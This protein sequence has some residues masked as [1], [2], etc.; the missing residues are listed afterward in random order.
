MRHRICFSYGD[1]EYLPIITILGANLKQKN[2]FFCE[3]TTAI[4][5]GSYTILHC[6]VIKE[7]AVLILSTTDITDG[8]SVP[9]TM[10]ESIQMFITY[11]GAGFLRGFLYIKGIEY[12]IL[13][14]KTYMSMQI[15][16]CAYDNITII[17]LPNEFAGGNYF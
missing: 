15:E 11:D 4:K 17:R 14:Y 10:S 9:E 12:P 1:D 13:Q 6:E 7:N 8:S 3:S 5:N 2:L 16:K